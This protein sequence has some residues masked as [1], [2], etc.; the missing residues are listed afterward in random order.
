MPSR[1]FLEMNFAAFGHQ[2][3]AKIACRFQIVS[4]LARD[5]AFKGTGIE[6]EA[7]RQL[8]T[9][10]ELF[11]Q[12]VRFRE[13][14]Q[15]LRFGW[16]SVRRPPKSARLAE[17]VAEGL[18]MAEPGIRRGQPTLAHASHCGVARLGRNPV[19]FPDPRNELSGK[20]GNKLRISTEDGFD[21]AASTEIRQPSIAYAMMTGVQTVFIGVPCGSRA[22]VVRWRSRFGAFEMDCAIHGRE[23]DERAASAQ[24]AVKLLLPG[25][26]IFLG[27]QVEI[28]ADGAIDGFGRD[29]RVD[30]LRKS[31]RKTPVD[32]L[33]RNFVFHFEQTGFDRAVDRGERGFA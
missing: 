1:E 4:G 24:L 3:I 28:T 5:I 6:E 33:E 31:K 12:P 16:I 21:S 11:C 10:G 32:G 17:H 22:S 18:R 13:S 2:D 15:F 27:L 9:G 20:K 30:I 23:G 7:Q 8:W 26:A 25:P 29:I 14:V 19:G